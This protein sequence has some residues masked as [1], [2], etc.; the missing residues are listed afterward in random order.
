MVDML[1]SGTRWH[2]CDVSR[3]V[4]HEWV[5]QGNVVLGRKDANAHSGFMMGES[6]VRRLIAHHIGGTIDDAQRI[7]AICSID[8][9]LL[10]F[11][12]AMHS[13][14]VDKVSMPSPS[15]VIVNTAFIDAPGEWS[16]VEWSGVEW[17]GVECS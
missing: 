2:T 13:A 14:A 10:S 12:R 4:R 7:V 15:F 16:G 9:F 6:Q 8:E 5:D 1:Q 3:A 11:A 17:S